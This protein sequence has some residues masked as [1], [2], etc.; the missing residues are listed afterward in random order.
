MIERRVYDPLLSTCRQDYEFYMINI[1]PK[2]ALMKGLIVRNRIL[3]FSNLVCQVCCK[4]PR[5]LA[6]FFPVEWCL[7]SKALRIVVFDLLNLDL[8][9]GKVA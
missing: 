1:M 2:C 9:V 5:N 7:F 6:I 8:D 3:N 4:I